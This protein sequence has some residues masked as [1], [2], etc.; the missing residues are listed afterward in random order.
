MQSAEPTRPGDAWHAVWSYHRLLFLQ[1]QIPVKGLWKLGEEFYIVCP[2]LNDGLQAKDGRPIEEW[3][4]DNRALV[5]PIS[6]QKEIPNEAIQVKE[7]TRE[8]LATLQDQ[9]FTIR[10]FGLHLDLLFPRSFPKF[11]IDFRP[12]IA[13]LFVATQLTNEEIIQAHGTIGPFLASYPGFR[14]EIVVAPEKF[15]KPEQPPSAPIHR[16]LEQGILVL[17]ARRLPP[18]L[19]PVI[20]DSIEED[21]EFW[22]SHRAEIMGGPVTDPSPLLGP[23]FQAEGPKCLIDASVW[24]PRDI[25]TSLTLF[26][27]VNLIAPLADH[28]QV[29]LNNLGVS[30]DDLVTLAHRG[31]VRVLLPQPITRYSQSFIQKLCELPSKPFVLT[32]RL[33][34]ATVADSRRRFPLLHPPIGVSGRR[35][36]IEAL[37]RV[38]SQI[39]EGW[40]AGLIEALGE[41]WLRSD[42]DLHFMGA[43]ADASFGFGRVFGEML[44]KARG[45]DR[46]IEMMAA[47]STVQWAGALNASIMPVGGDDPD[48][49]W[50]QQMTELCASSYSGAIPQDT[51]ATIGRTELLVEGLLEL[52]GD[53]SVLEL[54]DAFSPADTVKFGRLIHERMSSLS[55]EVAVRK[56]IRDMND[57]VRTYAKKTE[58]L[59]KLDLFTPFGAIAGGAIGGVSGSLMGSLGSWMLKLVFSGINPADLVHG[60][61]LDWILAM[62][63]YTTPD[64]VLVSRLRKGTKDHS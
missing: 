25:R 29:A 51:L 11:Y 64:V 18:T 47:S 40:R 14:L 13:Y 30:E 20:V 26:N 38:D 9:T 6:L 43:M 16:Q 1:P 23:S 37:Q 61:L 60:D 3:F 62:N 49:R 7:S 45:I 12:P 41:T 17:P 5:C 28:H 54:A 63:A 36:F 21:D 32:R 4:H 27:H 50:L 34:A 15:Q 24:P 39:P 8:E 31:R 58:S 35:A 2:G 19:P 53:V 10:D 33:A 52:K 48:L 46:R 22:I 44:L 55:D 42:W 57:K 56:S 59:A